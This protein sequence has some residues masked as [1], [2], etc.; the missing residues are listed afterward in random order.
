MIL[1]DDNFGFWSSP[2]TPADRVIAE[3]SVFYPEPTELAARKLVERVIGTSFF[4]WL[5]ANVTYAKLAF[6]EETSEWMGAL[7]NAIGTPSG[8]RFISKEISWV[9]A[10]LYRLIRLDPSF[11]G[12]PDYDKKMDE[13]AV[14]FLRAVYG[15]D[16]WPW[17]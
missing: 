9:A 3:P 16:V 8:R 15:D 4:V 10:G 6:N 1:C 12:D 14:S 13:P 11:V 2:L 5:D 17:Q 7:C